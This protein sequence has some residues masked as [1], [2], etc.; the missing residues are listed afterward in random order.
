MCYRIVFILIFSVFAS[1]LN[2]QVKESN[3]VAFNVLKEIA[4]A[5]SNDD[6]IFPRGGFVTY[7]KSNWSSKYKID[8]NSFY[9]GLI[10]FN[11]NQFNDLM[12]H[13]E[14]QIL[15][16]MN[17]K[18]LPYFK[19]FKNRN[20]LTYNFWPKYPPV[21]FPNGGWL[22]NFNSTGALPDDIDDGSIIQLSQKSYSNEKEA[23]ALKKYYLNYVNTNYKTTKGFYSKYRT[24]KVYATWLGHKMPIDIDIS[25]LC[26]T[27]LLSEAYHLPLNSIDSNTYDL[28]KQ[29]VLDHKHIKDASYVSPHYENASTIIYHLARLYS[30]SHYESFKQLKGQLVQDAQTLL[31]KSTSTLEQ[32]LLKNALLRLGEKGDYVLA[33]SPSLLQQND[34]PLFI[35]NLATLFPNPFKRI[36]TKSHFFRYSYYCYQFNLS[37]WLENYYLNFH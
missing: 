25:V 11:L 3:L 20:Q 35:A 23:I 9:T 27:L 29:L 37:L 2:G 12:S 30:Y 8:G 34:Y 28:I 10:L 7:R 18:A 26:N 14:K 1:L 21:I 32:L 4:F 5:Q 6:T 16:Q 17:Q 15:S 33:D 31:K 22:N 19:L 24:K 13:D 36:L